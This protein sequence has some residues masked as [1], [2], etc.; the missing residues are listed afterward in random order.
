M[1]AIDLED[2]TSPDIDEVGQNLSMDRFYYESGVLTD[3][4]R[5]NLYLFGMM[6]SCRVQD[7]NI[8]IPAVADGKL[9]RVITYH[10]S[11]LPEHRAEYECFRRWF[12][13][14]APVVLDGSPT[15]SSGKSLV[16][17]EKQRQEALKA[18]KEFGIEYNISTFVMNYLGNDHVVEVIYE[19]PASQA[20]GPATS[21]TTPAAEGP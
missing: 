7:C 14:V 9:S 11:L 4:I 6:S 15:T 3:R 21:G 2:Y 12:A 16:L 17:T 5:D 18:I 19:Q 1:S 20:I 13:E 10:I 8:S